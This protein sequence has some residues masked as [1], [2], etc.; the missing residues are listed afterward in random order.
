MHRLPHRRAAALLAAALIASLLAAYDATAAIRGGVNGRLAFD[1]DRNGNRDIYVIAAPATGTGAPEADPFPRRLTTDPAADA[2]PSWAP[3][4]RYEDSVD[5]PALI[6]FERAGRDASGRLGADIWVVPV[7]SGDPARRLTSHPALEAAPSWAPHTLPGTPDEFDEAVYP[8]IAFERRVGAARDIFVINADGTGESNVTN[9]PGIDEANP[10]WAPGG[11]GWSENAGGAHIAF[12]R[13]DGGSRQ[14]FLMGLRWNGALGRY[15]G[16]QPRPITSGQRESTHPSWFG[17]NIDADRPSDLIDEIAFSGPDRGGGLGQINVI[18]NQRRD[19]LGDPD[20]FVGAPP[21][22]RSAGSATFVLTSD[23]AADEAP[24]WSPTGDRIAYE[25]RRDGQSDILVLDAAAD[26]EADRNLTASAGDDRNPDWEAPWPRSDEAY[27]QRPLGRRA[28][29]RPGPTPV[30]PK[31]AQGSQSTGVAGARDC[32]II[33]T[34][35]PDVLRGTRRRD[36]ICGLGGRDVIAGRGGGDVLRGGAGG[37]RLDGGAGNDRLSGGPGG[38][39]LLGGA[40]NDRLNGGG[41]ADRLTP[42]RGRDRVLG[43]PGLDTIAGPR[44]GDRVRGVERRR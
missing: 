22:G 44:L 20:A 10:D 38:D 27:P 21:F 3:R 25:R 9:T 37:D 4:R 11:V 6:A 15:E 29:Q 43:G 32:T 17:H 16:D 42:G 14:V 34:P 18:S 35:G 7:D 19:P 24:A 5:R 30:V 26:D 13:E 1:S 36:V 8:P 23:P 2:N 39:H 28:R 12:D 33:G 41:G 40:G 31:E